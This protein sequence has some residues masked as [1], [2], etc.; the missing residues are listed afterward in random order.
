MN[1]RKI[2]KQLAIAGIIALYTVN[3][4]AATPAGTMP[5]P[6]NK[7]VASDVPTNHWAYKD[8]NYLKEKGIITFNKNN[9]FYPNHIMT[10]FEVSQMIANATG[11]V[12]LQITP[13]VDEKTKADIIK[14]YQKQKPIIDKYAAGKSGWDTIYTQEV[15]YVLGRGYIKESDLNEF[16]TSATKRA[17]MTK[18]ELASCIVRVVGEEVTAKNTY[19]PGAFKDENLVK[20]EN[21]PHMA[22]LKTLGFINPD[23]KGNCNPKTKVSKSLAAKMIADAV[24]YKESKN[25]GA[26]ESTNQ[27]GVKNVT[28]KKILPK[29]NIE[30][31][32]L[33]ND[34]KQDTYYSIKNTIKP[35]DINGKEVSIDDLK[36]GQ[37]LQIKYSF[38]NNTNY[39]DEIKLL[40]AST[41]TD[42]NI[43]GV[44]TPEVELVTVKG[45]LTEEVSNGIVRVLTGTGETKVYMLDSDATIT[46][47][48][49]KVSSKDLG[50]G[51]ALELKVDNA[52]VKE[53]KATKNGNTTVDENINNGEILAKKIAQDGIEITIKKGASET[54]VF[55]PAEADIKRNNK[56][57]NI[58]D[59]RIGDQILIT[60][61]DEEVTGVVATGEQS[62]A[63][64]I[65]REIHLAETN[66]VIA[67][68]ENGDTVTYIV[69]KDTEIYDINSKRYI[70]I[71]DLHLGQE[72]ELLFDSKELVGIDIVKGANSISYKGT[73][74]RISTSEDYMDVIVDYD[75]IT[76]EANS[77]KRIW[78]PISV[79]VY[80]IN[81]KKINHNEID[82]DMEV[83]IFY[84]YLDDAAPQKVIIMK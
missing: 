46:L 47:N 16:M 26:D 19:K 77:Y 54:T 3:T 39:I 53:I 18:E 40:E 70:G 74:K 84:E 34:G 65:I 75:P 78:L 20:E 61:K 56:I 6:T 63:D 2:N 60:K 10:Y 52:T 38:V 49:E 9:Q 28:F 58:E 45:K 64:G 23:A 14:N 7:V 11:Y 50:V 76:E 30:H 29:N 62:K 33:V 25:E 57:K 8:I 35:T 82:E 32:L 59:L 83:I 72:V 44:T 27:S 73:V 68:L 24:R 31:H 4:F 43:P 12:N 17:E 80:D 41:E 79:P 5:S 1:F 55:V 66:K 67:K 21:R 71:R 36:E 81:N 69:N 37:K 51:D 22:Y 42:E 48:G 13:N 15:A